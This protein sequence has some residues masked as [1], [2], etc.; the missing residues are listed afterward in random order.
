[1]IVET[2]EEGMKVF[3]SIRQS[4]RVV[5]L[6]G[7]V[8]NAGGTMSG[9]SQSG[10]RTGI[11]ARKARQRQLEREAE[12][13]RKVW[14]ESIE[15]FAKAEEAWQAFCQEGDDLRR[16][17]QELAL[18]SQSLTE[19]EKQQEAKW[20]AACE[21]KAQTDAEY[22]A[23]EKRIAEQETAKEKL[24]TELTEGQTVMQ[25]LQET[26]S[27]HQD[28]FREMQKSCVLLEERLKGWREQL[29]M[30]E[31]EAHT[32]EVYWKQLQDIQHSYQTAL[33]QAEEQLTAR[34][35]EWQQTKAQA[36]NL[37]KQLQTGEKDAGVQKT[38][39]E[40]W[41]DELKKIEAQEEKLRQMYQPL[42][43][44]VE[45]GQNGYHERQLQQVRLE[46]EL[47][48]WLEKWQQE[49]GIPWQAAAESEIPDWNILRQKQ[50][51]IG[52]L[53]EKI[54]QLGEIDPGAVK[55]YEENGSRCAFLENQLSDLNQAREKLEELLRETERR[56]DRQ[57]Q[58]FYEELQENFLK[59]FRQIFEGGQARL[60]LEEQSEEE[61]GALNRGV[62]IIVQ[63]P[64]KRV[65]NLA[66]LSGGEKTLTG[67]AF[68]FALLNLKNAPFCIMDEIDAPLDEAN[69]MRFLAF[70]RQMSEKT[71]FIVI[72]HRQATI[73]SGEVI[74][75]IT[76][77]KKGISSA[78]SLD[79]TQAAMLE[80]A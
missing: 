1:M 78:I 21:A 24:E 36:E 7:D 79:L 68:V 55:E 80:Q 6:E 13:A 2:L 59:T 64:G 65:Q 11:L 20:Q 67:I 35:L 69:L 73:A 25:R 50:V 8:I 66:L 28:D 63:M 38:V 17:Q 62:D 26:A 34:Q 48:G 29:Q 58:L 54:V 16:K 5:S 18:R 74:Y 33:E 44:Q 57:F 77:A 9:G 46:T 37:Q 75:G 42:Q 53:E 52:I 70:V 60:Q 15:N 31:Q 47:T 51:R 45:K 56:I 32:R 30:K 23:L 4:V 14:E 27:S 19:N 43:E 39:L 12:E 22:Q 40:Q 49:F 10:N 76:M 61:E 71:Q 3:R 41:H 72:S